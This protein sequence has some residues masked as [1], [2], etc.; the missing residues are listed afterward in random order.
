MRIIAKLGTVL[1]L[2]GALSYAANW[3]GKLMDSACYDKSPLHQS[4][5]H[6][7]R[8][9]LAESCAPTASTTNF[10]LETSTGAVYKLDA[11]GNSK[12]ASAFQSGSLK[13]DK[14]GDV[15][16]SI[17]GSQEASS[18]TLKVDSV[19]SAKHQK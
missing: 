14:D 12:A 19:S 2:T 3:S 1:C 9:K 16:V 13:A 7:S 15:H 6:K 17:T 18:Q 11:A 8:E 4:T 10:A 5:D